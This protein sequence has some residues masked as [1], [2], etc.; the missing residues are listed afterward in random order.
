[1]NEGSAGGLSV[2]VFSKDRP[3][4]LDAALRSLELNCRD[5]ESASIHVLYVAST[6]SY[7]AG[8]RVLAN[9]NPQVTLHP[10][11]DF[12]ADLLRLAEGSRHLFFLVDDTLFVGKASVGQPIQLLSDRRDV[13]GFSYR[14]GANTTYC[15]PLEKPQQLPEF[16]RSRAG[17]LTFDWTTAEHDF[18]YPL[19]VSSSMYRSADMLP[20]LRAL[21]YQ[22]P[23]TLESALAAHAK[24]LGE[25]HPR[26]AS[27]EQ[28]AAFSVPAN[29]VQTMWSNRSGGDPAQT[30]PALL[31]AY[32]HGKRID[33]EH[34]R[35]F[36]PNACHQEVEFA[37]AQDPAIPTVSVVIPCYGQA[38]FLPDAVRS[39]SAQIYTDWEIVIV[40]DGSP[41]DAGEVAAGLITDL[42]PRVRLLR[43]ANRGL[44]AARNAG[45]V[46]ALGRY[47][48]PLDADDVLEPAMLA[49]TV[50]LLEQDPG[51]SIAY[52]DVQEFGER[53]NLVRA[54]DFDPSRIP[55]ANQLN[56]CSLF[57][58]EVWE[59]VGG[60]NPNMIWGYEDWDFW[61]GATE[62]G[63]SAQRIPE[64]LF[65][66]RVRTHSMF[67]NAVSHD[68]ELRRR[69]E[70]NHPR[71]F[72][73]GR[74]LERLATRAVHAACVRMSGLVGR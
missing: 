49:R 30:T 53:T 16:D 66:Y 23:N 55:V 5:I 48:L 31:D 24:A 35:G 8:Y 72:T 19:E 2:V 68:V 12:K 74:R 26:L 39:V 4:Q 9:Q 47:I 15:Y 38:P 63:Y 57:R 60:Y 18:G 67:A 69:L 6:P 21:D 13:V 61:I 56:Y 73:R 3:F 50:G 34:Y 70:L 7:A 54:A 59:A 62:Q 27:Y 58:R 40:D 51:I 36:V 17:F 45:I 44:A 20:L 42:G 1:V 32:S 43:Q 41:D 46:A 22:S 25:S 10:E 71:T 64:P 37:I 65:R 29:L 11:S 14:L 52:T 33:V 28:S